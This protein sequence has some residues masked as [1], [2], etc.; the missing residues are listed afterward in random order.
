[1]EF[2]CVTEMA[3]HETDPDK[4]VSS[5][6]S[7]DDELTVSDIMSFRDFDETPN[8]EAIMKLH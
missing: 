3:A 2:V 1:M 5:G 8:A 4:A 7:Q 6:S